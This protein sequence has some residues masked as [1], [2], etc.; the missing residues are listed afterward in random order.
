M[1]GAP[2]NPPP[3]GPHTAS[4]AGGFIGAEALRNFNTNNVR[5]ALE[6]DPTF[7]LPRAGIIQLESEVCAS[8]PRFND[9]V[10]F[11][12]E[13][14]W[15]NNFIGPLS[16]TDD[17]PLGG[18][19]VLKQPMQMHPNALIQGGPDLENLIDALE[20]MA[21]SIQDPATKE[22]LEKFLS[23]YTATNSLKGFHRFLHRDQPRLTGEPLPD[24]SNLGKKNPQNISFG[25]VRVRRKGDC[26]PN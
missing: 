13:N 26:I 3:A 10:A 18:P 1:A 20:N 22:K 6:A 23:I 21:P 25:R 5:S 24:G 19:R 15:L 7:P 4:P 14:E 17:Q 2:P 9:Q 8:L 16:S 11:L 12:V